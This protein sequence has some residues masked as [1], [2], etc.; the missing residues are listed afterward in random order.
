MD[1][2]R[3]CKYDELDD[4][5][6]LSTFAFQYEANPEKR[7]GIRSR[8][9][10]EQI[11][12]YFNDDHLISMASLLPLQVFIH[13]QVFSMGGV[14]SVASWPE[15]RRKGLVKQLLKKALIEMKEKNMT[16]S[17]LA[18][19]SFAF[20]RK[21]GWETL[22]EY[23]KYTIPLSHF[24][25][26]ENTLGTIIRY[27][28]IKDC[29]P[30]LNEIYEQ[31]TSGYNGMLKRD[32]TWWF[33]RIFRETQTIQ[34]YYND[35]G[36]PEGYLLYK[37]KN[38][39]MKVKE[40]VFLNESARMQLWRLINQHDSM[41]EKVQMIAPSNDP[42]SVIL[43]NPSF[44]QE[45]ISYFMMRIVDVEQF[46]RAYP[47]YASGVKQEFMITV[48]DEFA[49]WNDGLFD[50]QIDENGK[51]RVNKVSFCAQHEMVDHSIHCSIQTLSSLLSGYQSVETLFKL[52]KI[53]GPK[54]KI[55]EF[56]FLIPKKTTYFMDFF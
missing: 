51:A 32:E 54:E 35:S 34:V 56:E 23:K 43:E 30:L 48:K 13:N 50:I 45:I 14:A 33:N 26:N 24:P 8:L 28:N 42:L 47:F 10:P 2:I 5:I 36:K 27:K 25:K 39:E 3:K 37:V 55:H 15:Y 19:F 7:A 1:E 40:M 17:M 22:S 38:R 53:K 44:D 16:V 20:Y 6:E 4:V 9:K 46:L 18:P 21:Y 41:I 31:Y 29:W 11:W 52:D 49:E 12:G